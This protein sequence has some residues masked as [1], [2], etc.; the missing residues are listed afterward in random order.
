MSLTKGFIRAA[1]RAK[2][3]VPA[4]RILTLESADGW[5][6]DGVAMSRD[7]AMKISAVN[8]CVEVLS[9]SM[10]VLPTYIMNE[11][12]HSRIREHRL[13]SI[14]WERPND[15]MTAFDFR[16]LMMCNQLFRGNAYAWI[17]REPATGYVRELL[18]LPPDH[19]TLM[20]DSRGTLWYYYREPRTG[21]VY[22]L[23]QADVL[24]YKAYSKD[25][26]EGISVLERAAQSMATAEA[27]EKHQTAIYS[28]GAQPCG[29]LTT[30]TD[31]G[32]MT[33]VK[34]ADGTVETIRKKDLLRREWE[35]VHRGPD[36]AFRLA[37][38]DNGLKYQPIAMSNNDL[39]FV[40]SSEIRVADIARYFSVPL[41]MLYA[42]KESY[43]SNEAN[44]IDFVRY[45]L[46][47]YVVQEEQESSYK[48]LLPGEREKGLRI[49]REMKV[50]L[51]GDTA[52]Q[53]AWYEK[54]VHLGVYSVNDVRALED[55]PDVPG[56]ENRYASLNYIPLEAFDELSRLR[57]EGR[58]ISE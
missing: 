5:G 51:R 56:G 44:S 31:I 32:G 43:A 42:G 20:T 9:T 58:K 40:E 10:A 29:V 15:D 16:R 6:L 12:N 54:L 52:A 27:A 25:G 50:F 34:K 47:P 14:L 30:D 8:R 53:A 1:S 46:T 49:K 33:E 19:V 57:A 21:H 41:H 24:H 13:G 36:N 37:I 38:L 18:P 39:Q 55:M 35:R 2:S 3:K 4:D 23:H 45:T 22:R 28:N 11:E 48:L 26:I 17:H 7:K